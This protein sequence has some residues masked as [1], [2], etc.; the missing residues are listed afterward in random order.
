MHNV[1]DI[2]GTHGSGKSFLPKTILQKHEHTAINGLPLTYEGRVGVLGYHVPDLNLYIL[3]KYTTA[4]GGCDGIKT[5][6]EVKARLKVFL[7]KGHVML[8]GILVAHTYQPWVEFA[9][10][11]EAT[12]DADWN[13][14]M[15]D[16]GVEEC[17]MRVNHRRAL[18]G[19]GP[20]ENEGNIRR[21]HARIATF[22]ARFRKEGL[23]AYTWD[24]LRQYEQFMWTFYD[25]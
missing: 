15:L 2:R 17:V 13:F 8:E 19:K 1:F 3:G 14:L 21:D 9:K 6:D 4:C 5:Q 16:T 24:G 20:I 11:I 10:D 7:K 18:A 22:L 12:Y 25:R 23:S